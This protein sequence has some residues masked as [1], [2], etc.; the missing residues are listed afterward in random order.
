MSTAGGLFG[1]EPGD[2]GLARE[3]SMGHMPSICLASQLRWSAVSTK[4]TLFRLIELMLARLD[5]VTDRVTDALVARIPAYAAMD[6]VTLRTVREIVRANFQLCLVTIREARPPSRDELE[7][8]AASARRR[9]REGIPLEVLLQAYRMG[10]SLFWEIVRE[11]SQDP[12]LRDLEAA[13]EIASGLLRYLDHVSTA[14]SE[15][16]LAERDRL[17]AD[18]DREQRALFHTVLEYGADSPE[19]EQIGSRSAHK[20]APAYWVV[21]FLSPEKGPVMPE[22]VHTL[23]SLPLQF[24]MIAVPEHDGVVALWPDEGDADYGA[25]RRTYD[26]IAAEYGALVAW[27]AGPGSSDLGDLVAEATILAEL[28]LKKE[29]G[30]HRVEDMPLDALVHQARGSTREIM[31]RVAAPLFSAA[32]E[33]LSL[34]QTVE[35]FVHC[36]FSVRETARKLLIHRNSVN[37]RL[38]QV[39]SLTGRDPKNLIDLFILLASLQLNADVTPPRQRAVVTR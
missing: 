36:N 20:V 19:V 34:P 15:N 3:L 21:V 22:L 39:A 2:M 9:A 4:G 5:E 31:R 16:Y 33:R 18:I 24:S 11:Q 1:L 23:R 38:E 12:E 27:A 8:F 17:V 32:G 14:V 28:A 7:Q 35:T 25:L 29:S 6:G 30:L 37:Y 10:F 13:Q 26:A